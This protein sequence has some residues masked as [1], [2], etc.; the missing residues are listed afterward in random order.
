MATKADFT[1]DEWDSLHTGVTGAGMLVSLSDRDLSD[2]FGESTAMAKYLAGQVTA[3]PTQLIRE[4]AGVHGTGF[5][6]TASPEKVRA[7]T[8]E[9]LTSSI[10]TLS[11][12]APDEVDAL[13]GPRP[14]HRPGRRRGQG[15]RDARRDLDDRGDQEDDRRR[16]IQPGS[17]ARRDRR[18]EQHQVVACPARVERDHGAPVR[19]EGEPL[20][21][22]VQ[23]AEP[24]GRE[25]G[26]LASGSREIRE[27]RDRA[28]TCR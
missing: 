26:D 23:V 15:R 22:A 21:L 25:G 8:M 2:S 20:G 5:G 13:P 24:P 19:G 16:L 10:A 12:K 17:S 11:A 9:A 3:G 28:R 1:A 6:F 18:L 7:R 4:I 27:P 14:R